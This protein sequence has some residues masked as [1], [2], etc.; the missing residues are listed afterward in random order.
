MTAGTI[1]RAANA[2]QLTLAVIKPDVVAQPYKV[3]EIKQIILENN[4]YFVRSKL[5]KWSK[6]DA[7]K[8]Y[9]EHEGKFFYNRLVDYMTSGSLSAHVLAREDAIAHWR[10]LMGPTKV[11]KA[12]DTA[13]DSIR[14][15]YGLTDTRNGTHGSDSPESVKREIGIFF[16]SF[17]IQEWYK[18][19]EPLYKTNTIKFCPEN[20]IHV[21]L[22]S[23]QRVS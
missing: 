22:N 9:A 10:K 19:E 21:I 14:A 1:R 12:K 23:S 15:R 18:N 8:F 4:F 2:L 6:A 20:D 7:Q 13:P 17:D 16:P 3:Q 11:F 5:L